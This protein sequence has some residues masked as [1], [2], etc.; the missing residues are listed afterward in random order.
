MRNSVKNLI[1]MLCSPPNWFVG[2][3]WKYLELWAREALEGFTQSFMD[4]S[5]RNSK[6]HMLIAVWTSKAGL[7][8]FREVKGALLGLGE[9]QFVFHSCKVDGWLLSVSQEL[10]K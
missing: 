5:G 6:C 4:N 2:E 9:R 3:I 8:R 1:T 10:S 7:L